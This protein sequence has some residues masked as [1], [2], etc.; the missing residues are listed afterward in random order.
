[1]SFAVGQTPQTISFTS[2][3]PSNAVVDGPAYSSS[4]VATSGLPV[5]ITVDPSASSVCS[6]FSG[7]VFLTGPG[8]C[9]LDANQTGNDTYAAAPQM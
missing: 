4:A 8:V 9:L 1:M 5:T 6:V 2:Q 3:A 7:L